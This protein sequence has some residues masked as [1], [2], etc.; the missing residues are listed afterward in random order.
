ML[1]FVAMNYKLS[2]LHLFKH[3]YHEESWSNIY[4]PEVDWKWDLG[5]RNEPASVI[6]RSENLIEFRTPSSDVAL[7]AIWT[8]AAF[9]ASGEQLQPINC[10]FDI[11]DNCVNDGGWFSM[12][13]YLRVCMVINYIACS[14]LLV[15]CRGMNQMSIPMSR[16]YPLQLP[17]PTTAGARISP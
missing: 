13:C 1:D 4:L 16:I 17:I 7:A 5:F 15:F 8:G 12:Y 9:M 10:E 6:F 14:A 11:L 2:P 3:F